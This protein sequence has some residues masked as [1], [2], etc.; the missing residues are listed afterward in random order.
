MI[1]LNDWLSIDKTSGE[2]NSEIT[3][4]ALP[5][6]SD[7]ARNTS[8]T[9]NTNTK[10]VILKISQ[11]G[12]ISALYLI[13]SEWGG[14][15]KTVD[16]EA[17][18]NNFTYEAPDWV[19]VS[20]LDKGNIKTFSVT[21]QSNLSNSNRFGEIIVKKSSETIA[22]II[23]AQG[24]ENY[25]NRIIYYVSSSNIDTPYN[26]TGVERNQ[27]EWTNYNGMNVYCLYYEN[28]VEDVVDSIFQYNDNLIA[29]SIPPI[30]ESIGQMAFWECENLI[31]VDLS[32]NLIT[33]YSECFNYCISLK[34][35]VLPPNLQT[36]GG[37]AF[38][39][40]HSLKNI[41]L[42]P[43]LLRINGN[44]F[45]WCYSLESIVIPPS[46]VEISG[47]SFGSCTNLET[48]ELYENGIKLNGRLFFDNY[49]D[50]KTKLKRI[51]IHPY[52][53]IKPK[54]SNEWRYE[55]FFDIPEGG[56]LEYP[57]GSDYS[58]WLSTEP[59]YLGYYNWTGSPY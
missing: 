1:E 7:E 32:V 44:A 16:I 27:L 33:L 17:P 12:K 51:K 54:L 50:N 11:S 24:T 13:S 25:E 53:G 30:V 10:N 37:G 9:V 46:V 57:Q 52:D 47:R 23:L 21:F 29:V 48:I 38:S 28:Q 2:G 49:S 35:I 59:Y 15:T 3:L 41:V 39:S 26:S 56:I 40:C 58:D 42:P 6:D 18:N 34:N 31:S 19:N 45:E 20:V 14:C 55:T 4:T 8:L 36:I 43:N 5:Y 22:S